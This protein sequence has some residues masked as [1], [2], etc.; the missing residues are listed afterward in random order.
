MLGSHTYLCTCVCGPRLTSHIFLTISTL[1][2]ETGL[3]L[4]LGLAASASLA[5]QLVPGNPSLPS[6]PWDYSWATIPILHLHEF[7]RFQVLHPLSLIPTSQSVFDTFFCPH[8]RWR[9]ERGIPPYGNILP[10][11]LGQELASKHY[12]II[13]IP[14]IWSPYFSYS[15]NRF[16]DK[17]NTEN[18]VYNCEMWLS[19]FCRMEFSHQN[20]LNVL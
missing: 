20:D 15:L 19:V 10:P 3:L 5:S 1:Y 11:C 17:S 6:L 4:I 9:Y 16:P 12:N 13:Y 18:C 14:N 7:S 8:C 2:I